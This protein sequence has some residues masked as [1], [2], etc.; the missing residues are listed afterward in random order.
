MGVRY[1]AGDLAF[2]PVMEELLLL[3]DQLGDGAVQNVASKLIGGL[4]SL[5]WGNAE[6]SLGMHDDKPAVVAA[7][8]EHGVLLTCMAEHPDDGENCEDVE[9]GHS[10][11]HRDYLG[12]T[13][14]D[15]QVVQ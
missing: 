5:G 7:F 8:R 6:A 2:E 9:R 13:W 12:R 3:K 10:S 11:P 14:N 1:D 15:P 4:L